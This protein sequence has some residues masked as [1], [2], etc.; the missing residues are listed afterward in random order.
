MVEVFV[1]MKQERAGA[2]EVVSSH[3]AG[4]E[5]SVDQG[6]EVGEVFPEAK[7]SLLCCEPKF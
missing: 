3:K 7:N 6:G 4:V 2:P 5:D 1:W